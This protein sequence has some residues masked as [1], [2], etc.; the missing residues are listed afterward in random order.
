MKTVNMHEA[1][2]SL[3]RLVDDVRKGLEEEVII[4]VGGT[5]AARLVPYEGPPKRVLGIDSGLV[6]MSSDFDSDNDKI[7]DLFEG[8]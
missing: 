4:A 8:E 6:T 3:S 5:P 1:K 2:S 7:A